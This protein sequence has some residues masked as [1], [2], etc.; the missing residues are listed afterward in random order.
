MLQPTTKFREGG[1]EVQMKRTTS[2]LKAGLACL[3]CIGMEFRVAVA[4]QFSA[5]VEACVPMAPTAVRGSDGRLHLEYELHVTNFYAS[6]G[7]LHLSELSIG[8]L[9]GKRAG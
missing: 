1:S 6:N 5:P 7:P 2:I 9:Q 4:Q 8:Y 3:L